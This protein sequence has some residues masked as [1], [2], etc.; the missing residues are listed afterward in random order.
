MK[1]LFEKIPQ[2]PPASSFVF[3]DIQLE[4]FDQKNWPTIKVNPIGSILLRSNFSIYKLRGLD[5]RRDFIVT[6]AL[7]KN[8]TINVVV[9]RRAVFECLPAN[10][11]TWRSSLALKHTRGRDAK[12]LRN[13]FQHCH[14]FFPGSQICLARPLLD[15]SRRQADARKK[16]QL[17]TDRK[18]DDNPDREPAARL[19]E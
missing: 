6:L 18:L 1:S 3:P 17:L 2:N 13:I 16:V 11:R 19:D 9:A 8:R 7:S 4:H 10:K 12:C 5:S 15:D 14:I